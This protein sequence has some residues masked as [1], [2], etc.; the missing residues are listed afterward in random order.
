MCVVPMTGIIDKSLAFI[1]VMIVSISVLHRF[2]IIFA[3]APNRRSM[4]SNCIV[5]VLVVLVLLLTPLV[6]VILSLCCC[7]VVACLCVCS[8]RCK[9]LILLVVLL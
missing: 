2:G 3:I 4:F 6:L 1:V 5:S 8:D 9:A 7:Y